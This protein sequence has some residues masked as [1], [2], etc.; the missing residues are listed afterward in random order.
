MRKLI[1]FNQVSLD[2]YFTD[3]HGDMSWAHKHDPEWREFVSGNASGGGTLVFGRVTYEMMKSYWPTPAAQQA[4][5]VVA[6][7][8]NKL[9][10]V[11]FSRTLERA[12]WQNTQL[13]KGDIVA[14]TRKMKGEPGSDMVIMGSGTIVSQLTTAHL[15]DE[16]QIVTNPV[17]LG[18]GRTMFDGVPEKVGLALKKTRAFSNGNIVSWYAPQTS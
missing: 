3:G 11:V 15:I 17:V 7:G 1:V 13:V 9:P 12:S 4:E 16:Y 2:G 6:D 10:K 8:M 5:P 14:E 18:S